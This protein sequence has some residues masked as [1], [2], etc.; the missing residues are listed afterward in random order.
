[1]PEGPE[2]KNMMLFLRDNI[3]DK[4]L[5][6]VQ[7]CKESFAKK[8][9]G[10]EQ[11]ETVLPSKV[12][13][14]DSKGKCGYIKL[15]NGYCFIFGF[16]MTGAIKKSTEAKHLSVCF[17]YGDDNQK[18]YYSSIRNFGHVWLQKDSD[19]DLKLSKL[20]PC[21]LDCEPCQDQNIIKIFRKKNKK[22]I[23]QVLMD[24]SVF[25]GIGNY[26]KS[27]I[28]YETKIHPLQ[29]VENIP[30]DILISLYTSARKIA[31]LSLKCGGKSLYTYESLASQD[32]EL[33]V[34]NR[35]MDP[36]GRKIIKINTP[37][38]RTTFIVPELQ[39]LYELK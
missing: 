26:I 8:T 30:D 22:A 29:K 38:K 7:I 14:C 4:T 12:I 32:F 10:F 6:S 31:D 2:V 18:I 1:M 15:E 28:L 20:G 13:C 11:I 35:T 37:D 24:Q 5:T 25:S 16:G 23:C 27:E 21:I 19:L 9:K 34:Y 36:E 17:T 33:K 39:I 3:I